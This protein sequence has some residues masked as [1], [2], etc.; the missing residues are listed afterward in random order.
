MFRDSHCYFSSMHLKSGGYG[1]PH[2]KKWGVHVPP[3]PPKVTPMISAFN[4]WPVTHF[5][6]WQNN[7]RDGKQATLLHLV[8]HI[9]GFCADIKG[10][11][12]L[13]M[14]TTIARAGLRHVRGVRGP[15]T[16]GGLQFWTTKTPYKLTCQC[17]RLRYLDY[18]ANKYFN[19]SSML[20]KEPE[21]RQ[22]ATAAGALPRIGSRWGNLQRSPPDLLAGFMG[23][24]R[25]GRD[26]KWKGRDG[27]KGRER[28][29]QGSWNRAAD[30]RRPVLREYS[31]YWF[32]KRLTAVCI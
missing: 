12:K 9:C 16:S 11:Q 25:K 19:K 18:G 32:H 20:T 6:L 8:Y 26:G 22:N 24:G 5:Q 30:W 7:S 17:E 13:N 2:S 31:Y 14:F 29:G 1:T 3:Y 21:M 10:T 27:Q 15:Q 23:E 28:E 4:G